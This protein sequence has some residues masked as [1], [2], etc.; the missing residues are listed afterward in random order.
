MRGLL[1]LSCTIWHLLTSQQFSQFAALFSLAVSAN[2]LFI[3]DDIQSILCQ[4]RGIR[5]RPHGASWA[6]A[7]A[8][9]DGGSPPVLGGRHR[10]W[11]RACSRGHFI[12]YFDKIVFF[13]IHQSS[14]C[15]LSINHLSVY[16]LYIIFLFKTHQSPVSF[17]PS[18]IFLFTIYQSSF[19]LQSINHLSVYNPSIIF[20]FTILQSSF[21]LKAIN[22]LSVYNPPVIFLFTIRQSSFCL[23]SINHLSVYNPA[24]IFLFTIHQSSVYLQSINHRSRYWDK[25]LLCSG[26]QRYVKEDW[27]RRIHAGFPY[28]N[29]AR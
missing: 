22:H 29:C 14:F 2:I 1:Y 16:Y 26:Y 15:L 24:I 10:V 9:P 25:R 20:L 7:Q 13:T 21:C 8:H 5:D 27:Q 28:W 12:W 18:I 19:C 4:G 6:C 17:N 11:R 3:T 23:Q